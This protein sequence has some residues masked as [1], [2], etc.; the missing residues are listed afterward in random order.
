MKRFQTLLVNQRRIHHSK[1]KPFR[2]LSSERTLSTA[3]IS[4]NDPE[5]EKV[6]NPHFPHVFQPLDLGPHIGHLPNRVIM[7]SMHTGLEG[8]SIPKFL[9]PLLKPDVNHDT[10]HAMA[11]YFTERAQGGVGLMVTGGIAPNKAGWVGPFA[12][13]LTTASEMELH[14]EVTSAVHSVQIPTTTGEPSERARICLQI[15]HAGR[16]S[17]HP[18]AVSSSKTKSPISMFEARELSTT[19]VHETISDFVNCAVLAKEAGYDG[20]EIMGSEGYLINQFLVTHT[21]SR[22]DEYGGEDFQNR[23]RFAVDIV[24]ET[25][26][27]VGPDF[28]LIFRLSMLDLIKDGSSWEEVKVLAQALEDAGAT[29]LNTGIGW[30]EARVPTIATSVPR[31]GFAWVTKKLKEEN[32]VNLP[33]CA[34]NRIN[35][36]HVA[37]RILKDGCADLVSMARPFLADSFILEK[38]REGRVEEINSCIACNQACLDHAFVGKTASCLVNPRACHETELQIETNSVPVEKRLRIGVVGSGPAGLA[39]ATTAATIGHDVVLYDEANEIGGQFNMAKRIPGKEE[40]HETIRY[41][42]WQCNNLERKGNLEMRLGTNISSTDMENDTSIDKWILAT[43]VSP[44]TPSISGVD[45]P[46][47]LSYI[48]VLRNNAKV[49]HKVAIIGAGGIGFDVAEYL[50]HKN[51]T[52]D[53]DITADEVS[54]SDFLSDWNVDP[55]NQNRGGVLTQ[56]VKN[57]TSSHQ[58]RRQITLMQRKRGKVGKNLGKTTG[59]IH[60]ST[61]LK[62]N[63]VDMLDSVT[64]DKIDE[65]GNLHITVIKGKEKEKRILEVDNIILCAGQLPKN[66]LQE[67]A[68]EQIYKN[69]FAIGGAYEALE[70]D[71]K[72]AID[73][74]TRLALNICDDSIIPG[75]Y[76]LS[77]G[78]GPE[79]KMFEVLTKVMK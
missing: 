57:K 5:T 41:F 56:S 22:M 48:D 46:K 50:L 14:K 29:I 74:G 40:F 68:P 55:N 9:V 62:S 73:M 42:N 13:K 64:Y 69:V 78:K 79:E 67:E 71:A 54:I 18:F 47:V 32:I 59:W 23:M 27:A 21:N 33:L 30:H 4:S 25:R 26:Q 63:A 43:G 31:G 12:A 2:F 3:A 66:H 58:S 52:S 77:S 11:A 70:L 35:A 51:E 34:T 6:Q 37:E 75:K 45:H 53:H 61:L 28:I 15:L 44:R 17:H 65:E 36:P 1:Q 8:H 60:R 20:V 49:G 19:E 72:R 16:Y 76:E 39:F 7:G 10:L 38:A 24:K